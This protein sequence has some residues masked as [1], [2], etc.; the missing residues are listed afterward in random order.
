MNIFFVKVY[1]ININPF[2]YNDKNWPNILSRSDGV[3]TARLFC[4]LHEGVNNTKYERVFYIENKS[5]LISN[6][7]I[8]F[9]HTQNC[10]Y[11]PFL[12]WR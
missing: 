7:N 4:H 5:V 2:M 9:Y 1:K 6:E 11:K 3:R 10:S 12:K 8:H